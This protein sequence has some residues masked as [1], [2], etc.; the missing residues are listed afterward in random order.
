MKSRIAL[1]TLR[2]SFIAVAI[3]LISAPQIAA[4]TESPA[5]PAVTIDDLLKMLQDQQA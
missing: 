2:T 5:A 1:K 3:M 4:Q